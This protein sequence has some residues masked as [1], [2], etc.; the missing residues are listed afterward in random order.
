MIDKLF[1]PTQ[2]LSD[3]QPHANLWVCGVEC[4]E[5]ETK[6]GKA[7]VQ[8]QEQMQ[9]PMECE[10]A[11]PKITAFGDAPSNKT[12]SGGGG[13]AGD[14]QRASEDSIRVACVIFYF[15]IYCM[16]EY[17]ANIM[18]LYHDYYRHAGT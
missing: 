2:E 5:T 4:A 9:A 15:S 14:D 6:A 3:I 1:S 11:L 17:L 13:G 12:H 18:I 16:T 8:V 10:S 7:E